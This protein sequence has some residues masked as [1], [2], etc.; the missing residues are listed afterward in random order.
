MPDGCGAETE[1]DR[2]N[3]ASAAHIELTLGELL[4][5]SNSINAGFLSYLI[6]MARI[7]AASLA[8]EKQSPGAHVQRVHEKRIEK[9]YMS[10]RLD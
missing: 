2:R 10:D 7:E 4:D 6:D 5:A 8:D 1:P 9:L 3:T